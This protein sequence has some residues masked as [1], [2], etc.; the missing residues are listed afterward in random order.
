MMDAESEM[1]FR[2]HHSANQQNFF[3][4][5]RGASGKTP[6]RQSDTSIELQ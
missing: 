6:L 3:I 5:F 2:I 4:I 1:G